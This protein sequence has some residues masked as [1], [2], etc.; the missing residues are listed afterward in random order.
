MQPGSQDTTKHKLMPDRDSN[1]SYTRFSISFRC[2]LSDEEVNT[3]SELFDTTLI[4]GSSM[5]KYLQTNKL[6]GKRK[7]LKVVHLVTMHQ[8]T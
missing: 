7:D 8:N 2:V 1:C 6:A 4:I 3:G 5:S